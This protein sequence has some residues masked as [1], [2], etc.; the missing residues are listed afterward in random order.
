MSGAAPGT[1]L[2]VGAS[3]PV[4]RAF[5]R[6]A[7]EAGARLLLSGRDRN[8]LDAVAADLSIRTGAESHVVEVDVAD[9]ETH[10]PFVDRC[11]KL[12]AGPLS[13]FVAAGTMPPQE[14][15]ESEPEL[16]EAVSAVNY[17]G[18]AA[19][20]TRLIPILEEQDQG[21]VVA[22]GSVAGD[23]GRR[24]NY[25]YGSAKAGFH[26]YLQGLR[27]RLSETG[28]SVTTVKP[29]FVDTSMTWGLSLPLPAAAP[30]DVA[31]A[32]WRHARKGTNVTYQPRFW[33]PIMAGL[34]ALPEGVFKKLRF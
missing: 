16:L 8:D 3:S 10:G 15:I 19:L 5:A 30:E 11:L 22:L 29:G 13:V 31:R 2:I 33:R 25:G 9:L 32:C 21:A 34:R 7:G 27:A 6:E 17:T 26:A 4:A 18:P 1:W 14:R 12:R 28:V 20:L 24:S 23:R